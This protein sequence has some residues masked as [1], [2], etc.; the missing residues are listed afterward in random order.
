LVC[1]FNNITKAQ[2]IIHKND[3]RIIAAKVIKVDSLFIYYKEITD[4]KGPTLSIPKT[5]VSHIRFDYSTNNKQNNK[6]NIKQTDYVRAKNSVCFGMGGTGGIFSLN[7]DRAFLET[8]NFF[9]SGKIGIGS[10]VGQTNINMHATANFNFGGTRHYLELGLGGAVGI[11]QY[12]KYH[13]FYASLPI[14]GY[15]LQPQ[16][17]G[18]FLRTYACGFAM[19]QDRWGDN[20]TVP[21]I[22]LDL[23]F[24]F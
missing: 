1:Y 9:L 17:E 3:E 6:P 7:Y 24:S 16:S 22:A 10:W 19:L 18:F 14:I 12:D 13:K 23:G 20:L 5:E 15:R 2:D 21:M 8:P 4:L 11:G